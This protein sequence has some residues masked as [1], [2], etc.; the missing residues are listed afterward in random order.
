MTKQ[1]IASKDAPPDGW[2]LAATRSAMGVCL[3][4]A[5]RYPEAEASFV[6]ALQ[7]FDAEVRDPDGP[8]ATV[9]L[10]LLEGAPGVDVEILLRGRPNGFGMNRSAVCAGPLR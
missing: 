2:Y 1:V 9:G 4:A 6:Q 3:A 5:K 10:E 7:V 8:D